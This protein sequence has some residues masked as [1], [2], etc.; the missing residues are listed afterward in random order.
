MIYEHETTKE[1]WHSENFLFLPSSWYFSWSS[2]LKGMPTKWC[3]VSWRT[4]IALTMILIGNNTTVLSGGFVERPFCGMW[5]FK[6]LAFV[7]ELE[8]KSSLWFGIWRAWSKMLELHH[9]QVK[10][11]QKDFKT[12]CPLESLR[13][14]GPYLHGFEV[15]D[16]KDKEGFLF[17]SV[18]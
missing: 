17:T 15:S 1:V 7:R 14:F 8:L 3:E 5:V 16:L 13:L 10:S 11:C 9:T 6:S 2:P 12:L 18:L 4:P